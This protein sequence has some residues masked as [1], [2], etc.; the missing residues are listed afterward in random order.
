MPGASSGAVERLAR[1]FVRYTRSDEIR[2]AQGRAAR[3]KAVS[4]FD[5]RPH[6]ARIQSEI[7]AAVGLGSGETPG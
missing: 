4:H 7:L 6:A 1:A 3:A 2:A 5:A